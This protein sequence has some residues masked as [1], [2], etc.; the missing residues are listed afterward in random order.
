MTRDLPPLDEPAPGATC[1]RCKEPLAIVDFCG[2]CGRRA[3]AAAA[4][5]IRVATLRARTWALGR[6]VQQ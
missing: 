1:Q 6:A 5:Q 4:A 3:P 2:A